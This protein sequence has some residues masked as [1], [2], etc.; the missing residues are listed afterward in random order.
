VGG[1]FAGERDRAVLER[2]IEERAA[3]R[4]IRM[5]NGPELIPLRLES[6]AKERHIELLH[7]Q[8]GKPAQNA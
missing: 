7:I 2:L 6:W 4:Q 5:E 1:T 3:P 8:P